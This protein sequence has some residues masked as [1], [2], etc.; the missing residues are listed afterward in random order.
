MVL[1]ILRLCFLILLYASFISAQI[2]RWIYKYGGS[3]NGADE[4]KAIVYGADGNLYIAGYACGNGTSKDFTVTSLT[5]SMAS[6]LMM[7]L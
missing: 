5:L 1:N 2:E 3:G 6:I 4:A 7:I